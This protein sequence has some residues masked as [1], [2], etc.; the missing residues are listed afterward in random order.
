M[1]K[2]LKEQ[3]ADRYTRLSETV[4]L[5][6]FEVSRFPEGR[7]RCKRQ[8]NRVY[9]YH[10]LNNKETY[11]GKNE[12]NL[13]KQLVQKSYLIDVIYSSENEMKLLSS[14]LDMYKNPSPEDVYNNLPEY[15]KKYA[16]PVCIGNKSAQDW[17]NEPYYKKPV[18]NGFKTL[19]GDIVRSKSELIIAD[20]LWVNGIPYKYEC[21]LMVNGKIIHPDFTILR[22]SDLKLLYHEHCGMIDNAEYAE[23]MVKRINDYNQEGIYLGDRLFLSFETSNSPLDVTTIDN[24]IRI[25]SE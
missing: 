5:L 6:D 10:V 2:C 23:G 18:A 17:I 7:I 14:V 8:H 9:Y 21:P 25:L 11:L 16:T 22:L 15:K 13:I 24:L 1:Q 12:I 3:L 19:K 4:N 20:R